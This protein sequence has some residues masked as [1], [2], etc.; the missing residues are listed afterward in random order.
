MPVSSVPSVTNSLPSALQSMVP[1]TPG[2]ERRIRAEAT[3]RCSAS[4]ASGSTGSS[5]RRVASTA[6]RASRMLRSGS[7]RML[8]SAAAASSRATAMCRSRTACRRWSTATRPPTR[9]T[10][11]ATPMPPSCTRS[12]RLV[13]AWRRISS[14]CSARSAS[15]AARLASTY[16]VLQRRQGG[17]T[18]ARDVQCRLQRGA[19]QQGRRLSVEVGPGGGRL[20]DPAEHDQLAAVVLDPLPQPGPLP[21][22]RL[23]GD[24]DG[25]HSCL[26]VHV[27]REQSRGGPAVHDLRRDLQL[28]AAGSAPGRLALG[29]HHDEALEELAHLLLGLRRRATGRAARLAT[30]SPP[31]SRP[32]HGRRR[33]TASR[34]GCARRARRGRTA[35]PAARQARC[36]SEPTSSAARARSTRAVGAPRRLDHGRLD[37]G[38]QHRGDRHGGVLDER[39]ERLDR[40]R[41]VVVVGPQR[42]HHPQPAVRDGQR[43]RHRLQER[44]LLGLR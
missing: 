4:R 11:S 13:R 26:R 28:L 43:M 42:R 37:L 9:A 6:A 18:T 19:P 35:A 30:R 15:R 1:P 44:P 8:A 5:Y 24:L 32:A 16:S 27:E 40:Q 20:A 14:A 29:A 39:P 25:R 38:R 3:P 36:A 10:T 34:P 33:A 22:Q 2:N 21:D 12:R 17:T 23:V 41:P 31:R 7:S